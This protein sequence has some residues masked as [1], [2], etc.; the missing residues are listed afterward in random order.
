MSVWIENGPKASFAGLTQLAFGNRRIRYAL[1]DIDPVSAFCDGMKMH[2]KSWGDPFNFIAGQ[3]QVNR[4]WQ[5]LHG[6]K[7]A[8]YDKDP[9]SNKPGRLIYQS[10]WVNPPVTGEYAYRFAPVPILGTKIFVAYATIA[11]DPIHVDNVALN[12]LSD[13]IQGGPELTQGG[14]GTGPLMTDAFVQDAAP[15]AITFA[16]NFD[17]WCAISY[18]LTIGGSNF[19]G[20]VEPPTDYGLYTAEGNFSTGIGIGLQKVRQLAQ[21]A[22]LQKNF[23]VSKTD[24][25][26][27]IGSS[28]AG[29][30]VVARLEPPYTGPKD[31]LFTPTV[32]D[33]ASNPDLHDENISDSLSITSGINGID[34]TDAI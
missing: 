17:E 8:V 7:M 16:S 14:W 34:L 11:A 21:L 1:I 28:G 27:Y 30:E 3:P 20:G 2:L 18:T 15:T 5:G 23:T 19:G 6:F 32:F 26:V 33:L 4:E 25:H 9:A 13:Y 10:G 22:P 31:E 29:E 12:W 24:H